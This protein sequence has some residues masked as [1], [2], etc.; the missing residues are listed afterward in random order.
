MGPAFC[1]IKL[2]QGVLKLQAKYEN[3]LIITL[4]LC[5][6]TYIPYNRY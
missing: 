5:L 4:H 6:A 3:T 1:S 2:S